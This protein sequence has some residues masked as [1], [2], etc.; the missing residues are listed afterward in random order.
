MADHLESQAAQRP[1][2]AEKTAQT[3]TAAGKPAEGE[4]RSFADNGAGSPLGLQ[5]A[6]RTAEAGKRAAQTGAPADLLEFWRAPFDSLPAMQME[7]GRLF[8]EFWRSAMGLGALPA[9][10]ATQPFAGFSPGRLFG[11]PPVDLTETDAAY[12]LALEVP[13]MTLAD[14]DLAVEGDNLVVCGHKSEEHKD[15]TTT[16]RLSER[17]FGRFERRFPIAADVNRSAIEASY[18]DGVLHITLPRKATAEKARSRIAI[19]G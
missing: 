19:K 13:G 18:K 11:Q 14:L 4:R 17:R 2:T 9:M 8:D 12:S 15:A 10:R 3:K 7:A 6:H 5:V 16:Y 1:E